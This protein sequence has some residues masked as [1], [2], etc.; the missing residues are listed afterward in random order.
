MP[1]DD[2]FMGSSFSNYD[3]TENRMSD[4]APG[5]GHSGGNGEK[6]FEVFGKRV[7]TGRMAAGT[8]TLIV[9]EVIA[10]AS[11]VDGEYGLAS[12]IAMIAGFAGAALIWFLKIGKE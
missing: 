10:V 8:V 7:S 6:H 1:N 11:K 9:C 12:A 4:S 2:D 5:G 3:T